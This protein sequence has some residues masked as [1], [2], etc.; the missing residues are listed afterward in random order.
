MFKG[1]KTLYFFILKKQEKIKM[2]NGL[3][4]FSNYNIMPL[5][6]ENS[7]IPNSTNNKI[8]KNKYY[9]P[10]TVFYP[11][12]VRQLQERVNNLDNELPIF[13]INQSYFNEGT[14]R[15][16]KPGIYKLTED[17]IF[18][19][20]EKNDFQPTAQQIEQNLFNKKTFALGFFAAIT[21]ESNNVI[22]DLNGFEIKQSEKHYKRQRF[23]ANIELGNSPFTPKNGPSDFGDVFKPCE[24]IWVTNGTLG[25]SSHHGIHGNNSKN[26]CFTELNIIDFEVGGISLNGCN[27]VIC[28]YLTISGIQN[29]P[30]NHKL[31]H[32]IICKPLLK[33][34][35]ENR[36]DAMLNGK[37]IKELYDEL[38][39]VIENGSELTN[40]NP[41]NL[42]DGNM[43]GCSFNGEGP[44]IGKFVESP[45]EK[46][47]KNI[48]VANILI[49]S[50]RSKVIEVPAY[51]RTN[52]ETTQD[53]TGYNSNVLKGPIGQ[54]FDLKQVMNID[55]SYN[56]NILADTQIILA[57]YS[58]KHKLEQYI[59]DWADGKI[60]FIQVDEDYFV[61]GL[62]NMNHV[63]KGNIGIFFS[64]INGG[65]IQNVNI[66][67]MINMADNKFNSNHPGLDNS[68]LSIVACD[69]II[70]KYV[71][72]NN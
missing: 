63:M 65:L 59:I 6:I 11:Y 50:L 4:T 19:P 48:F 25:K 3:K 52:D 32:L 56:S 9:T 35:M 53:N 67:E 27:N 20:N 10:G 58:E 36:P 18:N 55:G 1:V 60:D 43:Y 54:V 15:I 47:A 12:W 62:D 34:L 2:S 45:N 16:I 5:Y 23:Y 51:V 68:A 44:L 66:E 14:Y 42:S 30:F 64:N 33:K 46:A 28:Q 72:I 24:N 21:I 31:V 7:S 71:G 13:Q 22:I 38:T 17:I 39:R 40:N 61:Y 70:I 29:V 41:L 8:I 49:K 37:S 69:N 57:K 26:L